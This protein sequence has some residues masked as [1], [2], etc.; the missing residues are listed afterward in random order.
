MTNEA[1][2]E[3]VVDYLLSEVE[4]EMRIAAQVGK[5]PPL[6]SIL[7]PV[8][9]HAHFV[10]ATLDTLL[11]QTYPNWEAVIVNDGSTDDTPQVLESYAKKDPRFRVFNKTNGGVGSALNYGLRQVRGHWIGWLSSDDFYQPDKLEIHRQAF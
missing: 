7:V 3:R 9:N 11:A 5:E 6:F 2:R 10:P 8:Y 4:S 1:L